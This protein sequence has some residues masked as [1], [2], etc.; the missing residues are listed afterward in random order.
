MIMG[1]GLSA[2]AFEAAGAEDARIMTFA[3]IRAPVPRASG[4]KSH[5]QRRQLA[6]TASPSQFNRRQP[7]PTA[8]PSQS[9]RRRPHP[10]GSP[11]ASGDREG[12]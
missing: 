4:R 8:S 10:T 12:H 1:G 3:G 6:P 7:A 9:N 11:P 2:G 5:I